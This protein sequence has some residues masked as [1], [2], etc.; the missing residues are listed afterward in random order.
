MSNRKRPMSKIE[1]GSP[2]GLKRLRMLEEHPELKRENA[3]LKRELATEREARE[4]Y[5]TAL[6]NSSASTQNLEGRG[7][8]GGAVSAVKSV[9]EGTWAA[10]RSSRGRLAHAIY[11]KDQDVFERRRSV[12]TCCRKTRANVLL[13]TEELGFDLDAEEQGGYRTCAFC[14]KGVRQSEATMRFSKEER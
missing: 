13:E 4:A 2:D 6:E 10:A 1:K 3:R 12:L 7:D 14:V 8:E 11:V 9:G 5:M